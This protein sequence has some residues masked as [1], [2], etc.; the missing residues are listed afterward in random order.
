MESFRQSSPR[1]KAT[2]LL[3]AAATIGGFYLLINSIVN[4]PAPREPEACRI[5]D[6]SEPLPPFMEGMDPITY[7]CLGEDETVAPNLVGQC[8][9]GHR[10]TNQIEIVDAS[11]R[12]GV[13]PLLNANE[14]C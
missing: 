6:L 1:E 13:L 10:I 11:G 3:F 2:S 12:R 8:S 14:T 7:F 4:R 9:I 5:A